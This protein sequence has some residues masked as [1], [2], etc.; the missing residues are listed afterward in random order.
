VSRATHAQWVEV[1]AE[2]IDAGEVKA[3]PGIL[4]A[5]ALDGYGHEAEEARRQILAA[6]APTS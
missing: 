2:A 3:V 5:M 4:V 6:T 1:L